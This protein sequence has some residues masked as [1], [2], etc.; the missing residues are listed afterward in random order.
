MADPIPA[1]SRG[2]MLILVVEKDPHVRELEAHFLAQ[3]GYSVEFVTDGLSALEQAQ[4]LRPDIIITEILVPKLDGLALCRQL[5]AAAQTRH[6]SILIFSILAASGRA[7]EAG[8]DAFLMKP[9]A[10]HRLITTVRGL[11]E[12][13]SRS[14]AETP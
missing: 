6:I 11:L 3:A 9:L 13:R 7:K 4:H 5:K 1:T 8:A 14:L 10:E 2:K 12:H